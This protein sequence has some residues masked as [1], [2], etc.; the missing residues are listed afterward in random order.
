MLTAEQFRYAI[1]Q[2]EQEVSDYTWWSLT[3]ADRGALDS[4]KRYAE[5]ADRKRKHLANLKAEISSARDAA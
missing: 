5:V 3:A 2:L 4:S 1:R